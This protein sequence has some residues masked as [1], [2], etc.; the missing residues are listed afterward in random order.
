MS[1]RSR[2]KGIGYHTFKSFEDWADANGIGDHPDDWKFNWECWSSG[3]LQAILDH[4]DLSRKEAMD[5]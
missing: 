4:T 5:A 1:G 2:L 3:Y